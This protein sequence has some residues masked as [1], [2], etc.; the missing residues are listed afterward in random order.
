MS[1]VTVVDTRSASV[2]SR[3]AIQARGFAEGDSVF[4]EI[5]DQIV[6]ELENAMKGGMDDTGCSR[7]CVGPLAGGSHGHCGVDR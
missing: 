1:V 3:P 4:A 6:T 7:W 5:T 2:V